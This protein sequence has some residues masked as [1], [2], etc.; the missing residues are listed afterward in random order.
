M[1]VVVVVVVVVRGGEGDDDDL[2]A[3]EERG[4]STV[5]VM[6]GEKAT[7]SIS[8][9]RL[10]ASGRASSRTSRKCSLQ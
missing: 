9:P 8:V 4:S 10:V 1:V 6:M 5:R 7:S 3:G 2:R